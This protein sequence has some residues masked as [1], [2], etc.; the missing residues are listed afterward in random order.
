MLIYFILGSTSFVVVYDMF[1]DVVEFFISQLIFVDIADASVMTS[2]ESLALI[3]VWD[4]IDYL[5]IKNIIH[6]DYWM[7]SDFNFRLLILC[8]LR[9][10]VEMPCY[11]RTAASRDI[12]NKF[13]R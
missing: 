7:R 9:G 1:E 3:H 11:G 5:T 6:G 10:L 12:A 13:L 8:L 2:Y 4:V